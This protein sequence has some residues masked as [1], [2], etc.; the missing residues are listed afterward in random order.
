MG[1]LLFTEI[2]S[3]NPPFSIVETVNNL[4][5]YALDQNPAAFLAASQS[6]GTDVLQYMC[7]Q[8]SG[9]EKQCPYPWLLSKSTSV[10]QAKTMLEAFPEGVVKPSPFLSYFNLVDYMLMVAESRMFDSV[11]WT[12]FK[13]V[14]VAAGSCDKEICSSQSG[15]MAPVHVIL[16]RILSRSGMLR[17]VV[18]FRFRFWNTPVKIFTITTFPAA[19]H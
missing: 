13:L 12:K 14:L 3:R 6:A 1:R 16:K 4:F 15:G 19:S 5:P 8:V 9:T 11:L 17:E 18:L 10:E 7:R 2:L